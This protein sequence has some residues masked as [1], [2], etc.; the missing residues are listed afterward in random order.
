MPVCSG[1]RVVPG[2]LVCACIGV[3]VVT[4]APSTSLPPDARRRCSSLSE[5]ESLSA[6]Y[7]ICAGSA[8]PRRRV[9]LRARV[10]RG[11]AHKVEHEVERLEQRQEEEERNEDARRAEP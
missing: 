6:S 1:P 11:G 5:P 8:E 10:L 2:R 3:K 7:S 9:R 4:V